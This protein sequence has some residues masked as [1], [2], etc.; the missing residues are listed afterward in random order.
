MRPTTAAAR[1]FQRTAAARM[2]LYNDP[3][4][5]AAA[6][7]SAPSTTPPSPPAPA[8]PEK[9]IYAPAGPNPHGQAAQFTRSTLSRHALDPT[10]PAAQ[11]HTWFAAAQASGDAIPQ[12]EAC[13]LSTAA[14][15][16]GRVS[17]RVVYLKE[18]DAGG[19]FVVYSNL[20]SSRKAADLASNPHAALVFYWPPLQRQVR[21]EGV[22]ARCD[23]DR[24]QAYFD[25][26]VRGSRIGA[27][28]SRQSQVLE[29]RG[30]GDDDGRAQLDEWVAEAEKRFEG[31]DHIPVP[32]FWGG[33]RIVPTL[34]EF[35][36][37][38]DS[39]LHDRFVYQWHDAKDGAEGR[40]ELS[41]LSP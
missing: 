11:F 21:V 28:A 30:D 27:W 19:G 18:L 6:Q 10:S 16:S 13:T 33:L 26:R 9:L 7:A 20:G 34:V 14:L 39:R 32:D 24:S 31:Q 8:S 12:P 2:A 37:G 38:R 23:R 36:Q 35:W 25:T 5:A 3:P 15:P 1:L 22:A 29:P 41:R 40:W 4:A 17:S